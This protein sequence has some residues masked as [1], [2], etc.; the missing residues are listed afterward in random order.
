MEVWVFIRTFEDRIHRFV[1]PINTTKKA[2]T[3]LKNSKKFLKILEVILAIGNYLNGGTFNGTAYGF[4]LD[5]LTKIAD[6]KNADN[7][8]TLLHYVVSFLQSK[9]PEVVDFMSELTHTEE[10][11]RTPTSN[12]REESSSLR[13]GLKLIQDQIEVVKNSASNPDVSTYFTRMIKF[14]SSAEKKICNY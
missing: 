10:A 6:T 2:M 13:L 14:I 3:Q 12:F 5:I 9:Y 11:S 1:M 4:K 7:S 8:S